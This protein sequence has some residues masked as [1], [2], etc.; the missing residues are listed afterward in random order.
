MGTV[1]MS[2]FVF[3]PG[4]A[5]MYFQGL[6]GAAVLLGIILSAISFSQFNRCLDEEK[7]VGKSLMPAFVFILACLIYPSGALAVIAMALVRFGF[8]SQRELPQRLMDLFKTLVFYFCV[9]FVYYVFVK[10]LIFFGLREAYN[11]NIGGREFLAQTNPAILIERAMQVMAELYNISVFNFNTPAGLSFV[12]IGVFSL[13][14][15]GELLSKARKMPLALMGCLGVFFLSTFVLIISILP[16]IVSHA[17]GLYSRYL[18]PWHV[19]FCACG[20]GFIWRAAN[21]FP[22]V[23]KFLPFLCVVLL[24][25][26]VALMQRHNSS[27]EIQ[28]FKEE[29]GML[30]SYLKEW[31]ETKGYENHKYVL[32][33]RPKKERPASIESQA[34]QSRLEENAVLASSKNPISI[35]WMVTA[36]LRELN[37]HPVGKS[38]GMMNC[39]F[40]QECVQQYLE[41]SDYV[42]LG[43]SNG[44]EPLK[45]EQKPFIINLS[46][47]TSEK[48]TPIIE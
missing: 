36:V 9:S 24:L 30:R 33:V 15:G 7:G 40:S 37:D 18:M 3:S 41:N 29:V 22:R 13:L 25:G 11:Q 43:I 27:L 26:P 45:T 21:N 46:L 5:F 19:F 17:D 48:I 31:V 34:A 39:S 6:T 32:I 12:F 8:D 47:L 28:V 35:P 10:L 4:Y 20:V 14:I 23:A 42:V 16:W 38:L 1:A 44:Q 2:L